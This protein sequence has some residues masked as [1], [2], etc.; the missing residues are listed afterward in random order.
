MTKIMQKITAGLLLGVSLFLFMPVA[1]ALD[2]EAAPTDTH[3]R[4]F[5]DEDAQ[6]DDLP[7]QG[8]GG[9]AFSFGGVTTSLPAADSVNGAPT[10]AQLMDSGA[11]RT[12]HR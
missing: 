6:F 11:A 7:G 5:A 1:R 12:R 8:A 3:G 2:F 4:A 9:Q 10:G